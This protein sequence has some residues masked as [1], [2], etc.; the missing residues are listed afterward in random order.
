MGNVFDQSG[1][2]Q[3]RPME[4]DRDGQV[5]RA[6]LAP[7]LQ[8]LADQGN[9]S[10]GQG[11]CQAGFQSSPQEDIRAQFP[12]FRVLPVEH[13]FHRDPLARGE[14]LL[15]LVAEL[16]ATLIERI[17]KAP[18]EVD[19]FADLFMQTLVVELVARSG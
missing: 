4:V 18:V 2:I 19:A 13:G 14:V 6:A 1:V 5:I 10:T 11:G 16:E 17:M 3:I 15:W 8:L 9:G 12:A 7:A